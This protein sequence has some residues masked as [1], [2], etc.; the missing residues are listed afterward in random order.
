MKYIFIILLIISY[1]L[2]SE[3]IINISTEFD[4]KNNTIKR[5]ILIPK[6][7]KNNVLP[8][9]KENYL[10][11]KFKISS[12]D[13]QTIIISNT[14]SENY[15]AVY[16]EK[17]D[18][19]LTLNYHFEE[20]LFECDTMDN[21]RIIYTFTTGNFKKRFNFFANEAKLLK[22]NWKKINLFNLA[23]TLGITI[24]M[25]LVFYYNRNFETIFIGAISLV[26]SLILTGII[27]YF[28]GKN[29]LSAIGALIKGS[30]LSKDAIILTLFKA[31]PLLFTGL[32]VAFAFKT[33]LFN[34]GAEGQLYI[35]GF[36]AA[37]AG[38]YL[39]NLPA[40]VLIP[41]CT[42]IGFITAGVWGLIAGILKAKFG[43]HEVI[44]TIMLNYIAYSLTGYLVMLPAFKSPLDQN[45]QTYKI[46]ANAFLPKIF[47][48]G[49]LSLGFVFGI[50][51]AIL[52]Y[53]LLKKS[54]IGYEIKAVGINQEAAKYGGI[55]VSKN[56][57]LSF[58]I[59]AGIAGLAGVERAL[60]YFHR[61]D[62]GL[63]PGY[64][65]DGIAVALLANNS[66][67]GVIITSILFGAL[68]SGGSFMGRELGISKE[69]VL[70]IQATIIFCI[71]A[72]SL[73]KKY[74]YKK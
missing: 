45:P 36:F 26:F 39:G 59:S 37:I 13:N 28:L 68:K 63:S 44:N 19:F 51:I 6:A 65:F 53:I 69:L 38:Y 29:P 12:S 33:G 73:I 60:G 43:S 54:R 24:L 22:T 7:I 18:F 70:I 25:L 30:I 5:K 64:G 52:I 41:L 46:S 1:N 48:Y 31:T 32:S 9:L 66:P 47:K 20:D 10:P 57:L 67:L 15:P 55:S 42:L 71:A 50:L 21:L 40:I 16:T 14:I 17:K 56:F 3:N 72:S 2:F 27:V 34:I 58:F 4:P 23:I 61:F 74:L 35:G 62:K 11:E 49:E 8:Y